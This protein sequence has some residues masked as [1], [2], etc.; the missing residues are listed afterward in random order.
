ML[1][2]LIA[3]ALVVVIPLADWV[4]TEIADRWDRYED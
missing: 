3:I 2:A 1:R 4:L